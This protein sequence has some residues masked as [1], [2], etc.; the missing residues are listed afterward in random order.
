MKI[1]YKTESHKDPIVVTT[2]GTKAE[3]EAI[4]PA[5]IDVKAIK[6]EFVMSNEPLSETG[7]LFFKMDTAAGVRAFWMHLTTPVQGESGFV[8]LIEFPNR[9]QIKDPL[10]DKVTVYPGEDRIV[11]DADALTYVFLTHGLKTKKRIIADVH[12]T[13]IKDPGELAAELAEVMLDQI[14]T[15]QA[16]DYEV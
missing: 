8:K 15:G 14:L 13:E 12:V 7:N 16:P 1:K 10:R 9:G 11:F 2:A 6:R 3:L 4:T 5:T